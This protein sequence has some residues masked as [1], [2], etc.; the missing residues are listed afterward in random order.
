[1]LVSQR[2]YGKIEECVQGE[3]VGELALKGFH[4]SVQAYNVLA[5]K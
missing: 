4:R 2:L 1:M 3:T 5:L